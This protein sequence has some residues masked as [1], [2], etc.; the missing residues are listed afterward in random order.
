LENQHSDPDFEATLRELE[1]RRSDSDFEATLR[2]LENRHS[3]SDFEATL[4]ELDERKNACKKEN[5]ITP[6]KGKQKQ[7]LNASEFSKSALDSYKIPR[8]VM[9]ETPDK[10]DVKLVAEK[11]EGRRK[12]TT[13]LISQSEA[14]PAKPK[15]NKKSKC[16]SAENVNHQEKAER[17]PAAV[18][19]CDRSFGD[20]VFE[21]KRQHALHYQRYLQREGPKN[22]GGKEVPQ[23]LEL[24]SYYDVELPCTLCY[25]NVSYF[26]FMFGKYR[27]SM[28]ILNV[29]KWNDL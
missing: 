10:T 14:S 9:K 8:N 20:D 17:S 12:E 18:K 16:Q 24:S 2:E 22:P 15:K 21:R 23:V 6:V 28:N 19:S 13:S 25:C 11:K 7:T 29:N 5:E 4:R 1:N 3:D 27:V 26:R